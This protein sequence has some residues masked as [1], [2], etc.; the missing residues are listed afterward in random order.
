MIQIGGE[1]EV[2]IVSER[3]LDCE[4]DIFVDGLLENENID[5]N[6]KK[7]GLFFIVFSNMGINF[8]VVFLFR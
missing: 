8:F 2:Y 1:L 5:S 7:L 4:E 3:K 6:L